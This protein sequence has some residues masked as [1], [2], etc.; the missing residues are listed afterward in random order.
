VEE[1]RQLAVVRR[2][3]CDAAQG[4]LFAPAGPVSAI[5]PLLRRAVAP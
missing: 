3:G 1:P 4:N 5:E 2:L